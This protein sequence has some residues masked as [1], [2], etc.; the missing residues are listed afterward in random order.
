MNVY[1]Y[2]KHVFDDRAAELGGLF[3]V[4]AAI[5]VQN[6]AVL[7]QTRRLAA[8][9]QN[10][11][12]TRGVIDRAVGILMSRNGGTAEQAMG[13]LRSLSQNEHRKLAAVAQSVIDAAV[14]RAQAL[15]AGSVTSETVR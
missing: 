11:L 5:A 14:R 3:A 9:L 8:R 7:D 6:A 2:G 12:E 4:P 1:A 15:H 13:R 10:S